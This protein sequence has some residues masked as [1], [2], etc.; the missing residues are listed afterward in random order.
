VQP[1]GGQAQIRGNIPIPSDGTT[2]SHNI[3]KDGNEWGTPTLDHSVPEDRPDKVM[4][5][6]F[7]NINQAF[8]EEEQLR[9]RYR[10]NHLEQ[11]IILV[12]AT[13]FAGWRGA[14]TCRHE[15][16]RTYTNF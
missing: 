1:R 16:V 12:R 2:S 7:S 11:P 8:K 3:K 14:G 9:G 5:C 15:H 13:M 10:I 6:T 4:N